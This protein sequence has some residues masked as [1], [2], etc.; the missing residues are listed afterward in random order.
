[1]YEQIFEAL[2]YSKNKEIMLK[3]ARSADVKF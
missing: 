2:G 3:L 1:M